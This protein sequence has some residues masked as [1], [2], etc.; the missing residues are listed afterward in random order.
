M[1][2]FGRLALL[3][4]RTLH[5]LLMGSVM[6]AAVVYGALAIAFFPNA[7]GKL[8]DDYERFLPQ[9]LAGRYWIAENGLLAPP[10]FS[11][12]FCGGLPFLANPESTFYSFPQVLSLLMDPV[13]SFLVTTIAFAA[14]G[15]LSM[16]MLM[17]Q[18]FSASLPAAWLSA[19]IFLFNGFLFHRMAIGHVTYHVIGLLPLLCHLL[20]TPLASEATL[21]RQG[22]RAAGPSA[23]AGAILA[24][25]VY[26]GAA[27]ML[28]PLGIACVVVWLL[29]ALI[30]QP[31]H[32]FWMIGAAAAALGAAVAA[33]KL[34]PS[35]TFILQ[36]P[37][38]QQIVLLDS[39]LY[40]VHA[41][42]IG[43]FLPMF[44]P[45]DL[46]VVGKYEF[47][48][49][50]GLAP[51]FFIL[52]A[53][54]RYG[55][56]KILRTRGLA[57]SVKL[58]ALALLLIMPIWLNYGDAAHAAW[59]KS[60]PYIGENVILTRWFFIY[61]MPLIV[62]TGLALDYVSP[63]PA[64]RT[65]AALAGV[66]ATVALSVMADLPYHDRQ[67]Y[68]PAGVMAADA[69]LRAAGRV[70]AIT[71]IGA[72]AFG[73]RNDGLVAGESAHPCYEAFFGY[74]LQSFPPG[75]RAGP[76][77]SAAS[78]G[79]HLRNPACYIYG[80]ENG[81]RP[82]DEFGEGQRQEEAA[83]AAYR[84]FAYVVPAWQRWAD[85]VSLVG[86]AVI[87]LGCGAEFSRWRRERSS[88]RPIPGAVTDNSL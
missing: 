54:D 79:L 7:Q 21:L 37:R 50:V 63:L 64:R 8:G 68:D 58:A 29:H 38:P 4:E 67:P 73:G 35:V 87:L 17:R 43:L 25:A 10:V 76:I 19:I 84:P 12:A 2:L 16:F 22:V 74:Q 24:Y 56:R 46:W 78:G 47:E 48:F 70:P 57:T 59:L 52:A 42:F 86:L 75:L 88:R 34:A 39:A 27:N 3:P 13:R 66:L 71:R 33:A 51:F 28:V 49:G 18:R 23:L 69:S 85:R 72:T 20:L 9:L 77:L 60:I 61:L 53:I 15:G 41:L 55:A 11:P 45:S 65:V 32:S 14:I 26:A 40:L 30:R 83:F 5:R 6:G 81:C 80:R 31:V 62:G 82:G 36:F 44:L 1:S